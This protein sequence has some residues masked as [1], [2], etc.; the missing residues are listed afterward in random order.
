MVIS[1]SCGVFIKTIFQ[2]NEQSFK[3]KKNRSRHLDLFFKNA[4]IAQACLS[5]ERKT[6][7][8]SCLWSHGKILSHCV[9][10]LR[11]SNLGC[12]R[13][14]TQSSTLKRWKFAQCFPLSKRS[15]CYPTDI[16]KGSRDSSKWDVATLGTGNLAQHLTKRTVTA[17]FQQNKIVS[18]SWL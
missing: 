13:Y 18:A 11:S 8:S 17:L 14:T 2:V 6:V 4:E 15:F 7:L 1:I 12:V 3:N 9:Y 16:E 10:S 5:F